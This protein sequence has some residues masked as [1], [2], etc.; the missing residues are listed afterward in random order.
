MFWACSNLRFVYFCF[1][2]CL[3]SKWFYLSR[4]EKLLISDM[5]VLTLIFLCSSGVELRMEW[6]L[7]MKTI[8]VINDFNLFSNNLVKHYF[9]FPVFFVIFYICYILWN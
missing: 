1:I 8:E 5:L 7:D 2:C 9:I 3:E 6:Y 4:M